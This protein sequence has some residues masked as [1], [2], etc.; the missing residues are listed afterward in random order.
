M[1]GHNLAQRNTNAVV[2]NM[3]YLGGAGAHACESGKTERRPDAKRPTYTKARNP[4]MS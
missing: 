4:D 1:H 3:A 2:R